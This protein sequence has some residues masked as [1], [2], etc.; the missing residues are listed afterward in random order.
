MSEPITINALLQLGG[1]IAAFWGGYA[2]LLKKI[3]IFFNRFC[4]VKTDFNTFNAL[5]MR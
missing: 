2:Y 5:D 3:P 1:I 4:I